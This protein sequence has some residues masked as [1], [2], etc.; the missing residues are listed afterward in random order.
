[1]IQERIDSTQNKKKKKLS[2]TWP[3]KIYFSYNFYPV[4]KPHL[5]SP[6]FIHYIIGHMAILFI[7]GW[8]N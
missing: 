4:E 1:M 5:D 2:R 7:P 6:Q 8:L 3:G